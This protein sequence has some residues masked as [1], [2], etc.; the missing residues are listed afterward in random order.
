MTPTPKRRWFR[1]SLR[2][3][4]VVATASALWV[5]LG[6]CAFQ[7][8]SFL[9]MMAFIVGSFFAT[10]ILASACATWHLRP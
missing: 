8:D 1:F 3:M 5:G 7:S 6:A 9:F 4:F 2:T 10:L